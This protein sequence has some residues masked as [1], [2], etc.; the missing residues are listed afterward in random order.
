MNT[1]LKNN[2]ALNKLTT[3]NMGGEPKFYSRPENY[4]QLFD[5]LSVCKNTNLP[6][7]VLGG[8]SNLVV[9]DY[10]LDF[11]VIHI[12]KP[13][14]DWIRIGENNTITVGGG[15]PL[16][17]L[18][19]FCK[20]QGHGGAEFLAGIPGTIGGAV[21]GNAGAWGA[22]MD[23]IIKSVT[24]VDENVEKHFLKKEDIHFSYRHCSLSNVIVTEAE[25][26]LQP[27]T[28]ELVDELIKQNLQRKKNVQPTSKPNAGC[29][30]KNPGNISA[31]K[32]LDICGFRG[33]QIGGAKVSDVHAN[34]I[35]NYNSA[36]ATDVFQIIEKMKKTVYKRFGIN[37]ELE[38]KLWRN[39]NEDDNAKVA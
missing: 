7:K 3:F 18:L 34:F 16:R 39:E 23:E 19:R 30:F 11:A 9:D 15:V 8:G 24:I 1:Q 35:C 28:P 12:R 21:V 4:D 6:I 14:F 20:H 31:G 38:V 33:F 25:L 27:R 36:S 2:T 22:A 37:L 5:A 17:N 32:L 29:I 13:A 10:E 26:K